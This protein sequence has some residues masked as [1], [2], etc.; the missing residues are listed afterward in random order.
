M[1][2]YK[3]LVLIA[4]VGLFTRLQSAANWVEGNGF[5]LLSVQPAG[6][7]K[8][9]F[10]L[11]P[12]KNLGIGFTNIIREQRHLTNQ[13]LLN[14]SGVAAGDVDGDGRCDL[15]FCSIDGPNSLYRNLGNWK[16]AD[17]TE[18]AGVSCPNLDA[19]GSALVDL[20]GDGDLDLVVNSIGG[21]T[22]VFLNDGKAHFQRIAELNGRKGGMSLAI[23]D[24]DG[25]GYLDLY[26][27][28]YRTTALMDIPN[29]RADFRVIGGSNVIERVNGRPITDPQ[30][31][32]RFHVNRFGVVEELGEVDALYRNVG[33]TQYVE[34]PFTGGAFLDNAGRPLASPP[35][36][37]GLSAMFRDLNQDGLPDL[38]VCNDFETPDRLWLNVG[39]G[40]FQAA[41]QL[42]LRKSSYFAMGVDVADVNRDGWDDIFVAD[43]LHREHRLRIT[44]MLPLLPL[45]T[46]YMPVAA[47]PQYMMSTLFLARGDGTFAEISQMAGLEAS[48]WSWLPVFM[49]VDLDGWED[50]LLT[51]G[52]ERAA[53]DLDVADQMRTL[54]RSRRNLEDTEIFQAR[55][56]FPRLATGN[57]A[58]RNRGDLT[59]EEVGNSWGFAYRGVS[60]G[61]ALADLD[62][63]GDLDVIVNASNESPELYR[64]DSSAARLAV[65]LKGLPPNT[66]GVGARITVMGGAV[67]V[68]A[69][70]IIAGG[71]Y[72]S[73][74]E[75]ARVFAA[76][77]AS[78]RLSVQVRW[79][80]GRMSMLSNAP[81]NSLLEIDEQA[82]PLPSAESLASARGLP[83]Q[84]SDKTVGLFQDVSER[85]DHAHEDQP[86]NDFGR[87][88][89]LPNR[90]SQLGPGVAWSDLNGDGWEDLVIGSGKG[91]QVG[92][93][94]N[95]AR[96]GFARVTNAPYNVVL[97]RDTTTIL[98]W[99]R[100]APGPVLVAGMANYEDGATTG[101]AVRVLEPGKGSIEEVVAGGQASVGPL[102]MADVNGDGTLDLFVGGR[103]VPG[104][105][106]DPPANSLYLNKG[107]KLQVDAETTKLLSGSG[108]VSGAVFSDL[109]GD[110]RPDL[111]LAC[112][113]GPI[114]VFHNENGRLVETTASLGLADRKGW[115]N[116]INVGDFDEDGRMDI[117][118]SN[119]GRNTRYQSH[120]AARPL[121]LYYG[122]FDGDGSYD[123]IEAYFEPALHKM[124]PER[125]L[126][127]LAQAMPFL[128]GQVATHRA[129]AEAS[130]EEL[131]GDRSKSARFLEANWLESTIFLNRG[132]RFES[133][134]LPQEAQMAPA[135]GVSV[136]DVDGDGHDDIFLAQNFFDVQPETPRY[137]AGR[138]LWLCGD[139]KELPRPDGATVGVVI[140]GEQRGSA[141]CDF[142][143]DG[144]LDLVVAQNSAGTRL[145][146]NIAAR[147]GPARAVERS[148]GN[149]QAIGALCRLVFNQRL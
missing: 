8:T 81:A 95:D 111:V 13:I 114:R 133:V 103:V 34:V 18:A 36:D 129:L 32:N 131:L 51:T 14:G 9:G 126:A 80:S 66:H 87:Q 118:A 83:E 56:A 37:W 7:G 147:P 112:D 134:A 96:G 125:Q 58:F 45:P 11:L 119:W 123:L 132:T 100:T 106:P 97:T 93:Y 38:Y 124:V 121:R 140:Y 120:R 3:C 149:P 50:L 135:F 84:S 105:Y 92:V 71:R 17:I 74:D 16:F 70:E 26:I 39:Q 108:M 60:Q 68:Q 99:L 78:N 5:R 15:Y 102:A 73:C 10:T 72:L 21:G 23:G 48:D 53:R 31:T 41:P 138:G 88:P 25:D 136:G 40:R 101:G 57:L 30:L 43:M 82:A 75:A 116:G 6:S 107:G 137:D 128:R 117:V 143:R 144:R 1:N 24:V 2:L 47:R 42:A 113:W 146:R 130:V 35:R 77:N 55:R 94:A 20:D 44:Q 29:A 85:L 12:A 79:R 104:K 33:G 19:T 148:A 65:R 54:R 142:D 28:N 127:P 145:F 64:N 109:D 110:G 98:S 76:G 52:H 49:D 91:G 61:M 139:G 90:L 115:W 59:F 46:D 141:L 62:N 89:L 27:A 63:D 69:Q 86:F 22:H 67:P 4:L 122:D